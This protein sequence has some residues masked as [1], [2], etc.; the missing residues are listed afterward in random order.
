MSASPIAEVAVYFLYSVLSFTAVLVLFAS[1][2]GL[3][4]LA[5]RIVIR[6]IQVLMGVTTEVYPSAMEPRVKTLDPVGVA[7]G[8]RARQI[9][10]AHN[11]RF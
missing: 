7:V 3:T 9:R 11:D 5:A 4:A 2:I 10:G 8:S 1:A 6:E